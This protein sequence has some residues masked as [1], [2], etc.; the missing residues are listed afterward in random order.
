MPDDITTTKRHNNIISSFLKTFKK[1]KNKSNIFS[2]NISECTNRNTQTPETNV[3]AI[4]GLVIKQHS[5]TAAQSVYSFT[6]LPLKTQCLLNSKK[7]FDQ[8]LFTR[9]I[10]EDQNGSVGN[11]L[12]AKE[13]KVYITEPQTRFKN[14]AHH[15]T[16]I[17]NSRNDS[18]YNNTQMSLYNY[19][20]SYAKKTNASSS[21]SSISTSHD[22]SFDLSFVDLHCSSS[23][24]ENDFSLKNKYFRRMLSKSVLNELLNVKNSNSICRLPSNCIY[25]VSLKQKNL[26]VRVRS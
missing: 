22:D 15:Y 6:N 16:S 2:D 1:D 9:E 17:F 11:L 21:S 7:D 19:L 25:V 12:K 10:E 24:N 13:V 3:T 23:I 4:H 20:E 8:L 5:P 18:N 26:F 14:Q